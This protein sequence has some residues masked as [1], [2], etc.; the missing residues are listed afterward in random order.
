[1][2]VRRVVTKNGP[3]AKGVVVVDAS[4][5]R[6]HDYVTMPGMSS[7]L[8]WATEPGQ[9]L[10][11]EDITTTISNFVPEPGGT[12]LIMLQ[13]SP[14][15]TI[16]PSTDP[17]D[18]VAENLIAN[19]GIAER[20]ESDGSSMHTT[21]TID[22]VIVIKGV[23]DLDLGD[24]EIVSLEAGDVVVQCAARHAWRNHTSEPVT[25]V[26]VLIGA[27]TTEAR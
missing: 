26:F 7:S 20:F 24:G 11:S 22:Y 12:R 27:D 6:I 10:S 3:N 4:A 9:A 16:D 17:A 15:G 21:P 19:P 8:L 2:D 25:A 5:P 14:D 23:L 13:I 1:M 18:M